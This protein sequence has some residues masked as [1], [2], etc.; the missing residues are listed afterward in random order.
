MSADPIKTL[1]QVLTGNEERDAIHI[2]I[3]PV[4]LAKDMQPGQQADLVY[5]TLNQVKPAVG[6]K[7]LGIIDPY[8][9]AYGVRKGLKVWLFL[10][11][12]TVTGMRHHWKH[13]AFDERKS[14]KNEHEGWLREFADE[15]NFDYD[16]MIEE[17]QSKDGYVVA[18]DIDLH[19]RDE[20]AP[21]DETLF[22]YHI[23]Q[24]TG[25]KAD[26]SHKESF[27]WSCSC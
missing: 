26:E 4:V 15:W 9:Q 24:L 1:G 18:R 12:N 8:I 22:W 5:G 6:D 25:F 27:G 21:G 16:N 14:P 23:E 7:G 13:P 19:S 11:P 17:A 10:N 20:L 3:I 2:A